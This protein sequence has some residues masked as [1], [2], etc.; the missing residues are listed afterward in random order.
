M[1]SLIGSTNV[2]Q[3][4]RVLIA[5]YPQVLKAIPILLAKRESEIFA[6][7]KEDGGVYRFDRL[8]QSIDEYCIFMSTVVAF[9]VGSDPSV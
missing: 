4:F 9:L 2:E 8:A 7:D 1:N 3:E 6:K 5:K